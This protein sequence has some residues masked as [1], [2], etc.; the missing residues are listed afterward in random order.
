MSVPD[1]YSH[2][3]PNQQ[4]AE[5]EIKVEWAEVAPQGRAAD[6]WQSWC[7]LISSFV[8]CLQMYA[9]DTSERDSKA[10]AVKSLR[11]FDNWAQPL[12]AL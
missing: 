4:R 5:V 2:Q 1:L 8:L 11:E 10:A 7:L 12:A 9:T 3:K 6:C